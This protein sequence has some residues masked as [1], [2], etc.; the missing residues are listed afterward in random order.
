MRETRNLEFKEEVSNSFL[1]TVSAFANYG[2]GEIKF[3]ICDDGSIKGVSDAKQTCLDI[4]NKINDSIEPNP[5]YTLEIDEKTAVI[6]VKVFEGIHKPYLYKSKAYKRSD[7][8]TIPVE[9]LEF[10]RL[11]LSGQN[12]SFE[13]LKAKKQDLRFSVLEKEFSEKLGINKIDAD[14]LKTLELYAKSDGFNNAGELLA[15]ENTFSGIDCVKFGENINII[16]DRKTFSNISVLSQF[17]K[18]LEIF[19]T[20]FQYEEIK[21]STREKIERIPESAFREA[22]ANALVHRTWDIQANINIS[23]FSDYVE[24]VS[25]GGLPEGL[26]EKEYLDGHI[27]IL[28]NPILGNVFFRLHIIERFGTGIMRIRE[29]YEKST[30][31]PVFSVSENSIRIRLPVIDDAAASLT[32]DEKKLFAALQGKT[33]TSSQIAEASGFGKTK[34]VALLKNLVEQGYVKKEGN[35]K[36]IKY[37]VS[38]EKS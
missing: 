28:R 31:K 7:S 5:D 25:P 27:S 15:D 34:T 3:G 30:A 33:M 38:N 14:I 9:R 35:G 12:I 21:G 4:E 1:K 2:T 11:I 26:D 13:S 17:E 16:Q 29:S 36:G 32:A 18:S 37:S 19:R 20:Y 24:I 22:V 23:M 6:T 8:A 10:T